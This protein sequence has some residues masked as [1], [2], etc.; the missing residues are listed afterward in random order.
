MNK[1][2][3]DTDQV[4]EWTISGVKVRVLVTLDPNTCTP[5][6]TIESDNA[7]VLED[8]QV[9]RRCGKK[10]ATAELWRMWTNSREFSLAEDD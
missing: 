2:G 10:G 4:H 3:I 6:L 5:R 7:I 1:H 8:M 9:I